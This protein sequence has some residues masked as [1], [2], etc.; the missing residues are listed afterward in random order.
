VSSSGTRAVPPVLDSIR[1]DRDRH[2]DDL[3]SRG[4][5]DD[6]ALNRRAVDTNTG[7][8]SPANRDAVL[9]TTT[10]PSGGEIRHVIG[11]ARLD[12]Q[13]A[14]LGS[15][16][17]NVLSGGNDVTWPASRARSTPLFDL[18]LD[19]FLCNRSRPSIYREAMRCQAN[20]PSQDGPHRP[21]VPSPRQSPDDYEKRVD[22]GVDPEVPPESTL[23]LDSADG[24]I[25]L[26]LSHET[27]SPSSGYPAAVHSESPPAYRSTLR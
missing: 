5:R 2:V 3:A 19:L 27:L 9:D 15:H 1:P 13:T 26:L 22:P 23:R 6:A 18:A 20:A 10:I 24:L 11:E 25:S 8:L 14:E 21:E 12:P 4:V 7:R 16:A 17:K